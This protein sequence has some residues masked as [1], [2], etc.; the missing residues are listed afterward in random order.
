MTD[1]ETYV[2][3]HGWELHMSWCPRDHEG[4]R[5]ELDVYVYDAPNDATALVQLTGVHCASQ[6][7]DVAGFVTTDEGHANLVEVLV[8]MNAIRAEGMADAD[9]DLHAHLHPEEP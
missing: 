6:R 8:S 3:D 9:C 1:I 4:G 5:C 7:L 2:P